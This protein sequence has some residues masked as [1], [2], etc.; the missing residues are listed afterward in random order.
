MG[1]GTRG[2]VAAVVIAAATAGQAAGAAVPRAERYIGE[3]RPGTGVVRIAV[4][5][6]RITAMDIQHRSWRCTG[7]ERGLREM[8][9]DLRTFGPS[10]AAIRPK[11]DGTFRYRHAVSGAGAYSR[12]TVAG[13][14]TN[15]GQMVRGT[16][17]WANRGIRRDGA[18]TCRTTAPIRFTAYV[19]TRDYTG[20][21]SQGVRVRGQ[22]TWIMDL[23]AWIRR[24]PPYIQGGF[25][26]V[27]GGTPPPS[28]FQSVLLTCETGA[29]QTE[30]IAG[31]VDV[32]TGALSASSAGPG[33]TVSL[34]GRASPLASV[35]PGHIS[36]TMTV[37][38][39]NP[40][41][42]GSAT[43]AATELVPL[44]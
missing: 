42:S 31:P 38:R 17:T 14:F 20:A 26:P 7:A 30:L 9:W 13:R 39:T 16:F 41:C 32:R 12:W 35:A 44:T 37:T 29:T 34:T 8:G 5:N 4:T 11:A 28:P 24:T 19:T 3:T 18:V 22:V 6:R 1:V 43:F 36:L 33:E 25:G 40:S 21:T 27:I 10:R 15:R 23:M 2:L